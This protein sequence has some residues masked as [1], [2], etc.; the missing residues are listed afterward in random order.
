MFLNVIQP[1]KG[2]SEDAFNLENIK[3]VISC[4]KLHLNMDLFVS[5]HL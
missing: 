4:F 5:A 1:R 3:T 2:R